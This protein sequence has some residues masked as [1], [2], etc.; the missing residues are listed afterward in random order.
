MS[1]LAKKIGSTGVVITIPARPG[2]V[3]KCFPLYGEGDLDDWAAMESYR[4]GPP[5]KTWA[6]VHAFIDDLAGVTKPLPLH[7]F[8]Y[9]WR[10]RCY[11]WPEELR[12]S[13]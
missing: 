6:E 1:K 5:G 9:H 12:L 3:S 10:R 11:C 8:K 13:S 4:Q 2:P 7:K